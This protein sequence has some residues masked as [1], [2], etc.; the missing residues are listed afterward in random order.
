MAGMQWD[1]YSFML[2]FGCY[3]RRIEAVQWHVHAQGLV[4]DDSPDP[5]VLAHRK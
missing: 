1:T 4:G 3:A 2:A 5:S